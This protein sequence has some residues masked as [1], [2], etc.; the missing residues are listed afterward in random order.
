VVDL[1]KMISFKVVQGLEGIIEVAA[2]RGRATESRET[3]MNI[4][5]Q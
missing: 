4:P 2:V 1:F 3:A 5:E